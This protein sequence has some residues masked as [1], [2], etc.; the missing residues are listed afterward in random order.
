MRKQSETDIIQSFKIGS[1]SK[2]L[3][4]VLL[5]DKGLWCFGPRGTTA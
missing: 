2:R 5:D 3:N 4:D 1:R